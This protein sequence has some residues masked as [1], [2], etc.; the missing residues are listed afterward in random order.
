VSRAPTR[1]RSADSRTSRSAAPGRT[2][3]SI[4]LPR[5]SVNYDD[6]ATISYIDQDQADPFGKLSNR[7]WAVHADLTLPALAG[8]SAGSK[9]LGWLRDLFS[10]LV[11]FGASLEHSQPA[12]NGVKEGQEID[13]KGWELGLANVFTLRHGHVDDPTGTVIGDTSGWSLGLQVGKAGGIRYDHATVPQSIYLSR[14]VDRKGLTVF[15]DP[16]RLFRRLR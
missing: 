1:P 9:Q 2:S 13:L 11:S 10:P 3:S 4:W 12:A 15:L 7:G 14:D 6:N 8:K 5:A 16:V